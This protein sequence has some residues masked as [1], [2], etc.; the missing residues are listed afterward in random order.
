MFDNYISSFN[1]K[2]KVSLVCM[3]HHKIHSFVLFVVVTYIT[4]IHSKNKTQLFDVLFVAL[5]GRDQ[6]LRLIPTKKLKKTNTNKL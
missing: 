6:S 2:S 3:I 4:T 5:G 1:K